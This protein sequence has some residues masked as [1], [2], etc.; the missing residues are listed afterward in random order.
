M[1]GSPEL[2]AIVDYFSGPIGP[3]CYYFNLSPHWT[4]PI[5]GVPSLMWLTSA[6]PCD[7]THGKLCKKMIIILQNF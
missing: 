6:C 4:Y 2:G 5:S 1:N 7:I 3:A